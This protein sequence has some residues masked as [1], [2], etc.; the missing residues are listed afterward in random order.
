MLSSGSPNLCISLSLSPCAPWPQKPNYRRA[1]TFQETSPKSFD[2]LSFL[3]SLREEKKK[4]KISKQ[5][6][7]TYC[8]TVDWVASANHKRRA[9]ETRSAKRDMT[10]NAIHSWRSRAFSQQTCSAAGSEGKAPE[11]LGDQIPHHGSGNTLP[12]PCGHGQMT[13]EI[14]DITQQ[15]LL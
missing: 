2:H 5:P 15:I 7:D 12:P 10:S 4:T 9:T 3:N 13:L 6:Y 14:M 1:L 8:C 11:W